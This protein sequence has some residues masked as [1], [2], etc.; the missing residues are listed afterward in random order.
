[1]KRQVHPV[2]LDLEFE[3]PADVGGA[4]CSTLQ[5]RS[6]VICFDAY[7]SGQQSVV[8]PGAP[9]DQAGSDDPNLYREILNSIKHFLY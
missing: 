6:N 5:L 4:D 3:S 9:T 7:R 8:R 2:Q 1:M